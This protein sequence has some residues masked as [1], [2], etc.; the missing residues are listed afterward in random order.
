VFYQYCGICMFCILCSYLLN[1]QTIDDDIVSLIVTSSA[2]LTVDVLL[3]D[4]Y[5]QF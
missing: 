2:A 1:K 3:N 5:Q 4:I